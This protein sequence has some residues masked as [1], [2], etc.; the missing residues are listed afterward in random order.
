MVSVRVSLVAVVSML[1]LGSSNIDLLVYLVL[2]H[3]AELTIVIFLI[4]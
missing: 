4:V 3:D 2:L 1:D